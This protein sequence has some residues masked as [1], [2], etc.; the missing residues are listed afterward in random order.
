MT[1]S[2]KIVA[3]AMFRNE[4]G[5]QIRSKYDAEYFLN[6]LFRSGHFVI[7]DERN[8]NMHYILS[9]GKDGIARIAHERNDKEW[10]DPDF[11]YQGEHAVTIAYRARRSINKY[12]RGEDE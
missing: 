4:H 3:M 5:F 12:L 2:E 6:D 11:M 8:E 9:K 7:Q 1:M 10:Y